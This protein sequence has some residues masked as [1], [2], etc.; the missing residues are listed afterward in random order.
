MTVVIGFLGVMGSTLV[1]WYV[2]R[3]IRLRRTLRLAWSG[4]DGHRTAAR[5]FLEA[6]GYELIRQTETAGWIGY[7]DMQSHEEKFFVDFIVRKDGAYYAVKVIC[8]EGESESTAHTLLANCFPLY[9]LLDVKGILV[10]N[11]HRETL[12]ILDYDVFIPKFVRW[13]RRFRLSGVFAVG[14]MIGMV[15]LNHH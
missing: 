7:A 2:A 14:V 15:L 6:Q 8:A 10:V 5:R 12:H 4:M 11:L 13:R 9:S 3:N 1:F